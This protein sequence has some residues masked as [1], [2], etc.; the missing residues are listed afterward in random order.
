MDS[1]RGLS[2]T[3]T[4]PPLYAS[5]WALDLT[6]SPRAALALNLVSLPLFALFTCVFGLISSIF[7]PGMLT[8]LPAV[9]FSSHS[10][11]VLLSFLLAVLGIMIL[12]EA[13]HGAFFWIYTHARPVFGMR[14]LFAYAG[15]P[16][17]YIPR[18]KYSVI[19]LAP[20]TLIS[21]A[22]LIAI[23]F[24]PLVTAQFILLTIT[25]N[26]AGAVGDLY[27]V[28]KILRQSPTILIQ[29]TGAGFT[30]FGEIQ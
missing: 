30:V 13:I 10:T 1:T 24:L 15:A 4:L 16:E 21:L 11:F 2:S 14:I 3:R 26:A 25:V 7:H 22:G 12:H 9:L 6:K 18:D 23:P 29:D 5:I 27:V 19:G 17:W 8:S 20:F 28:A